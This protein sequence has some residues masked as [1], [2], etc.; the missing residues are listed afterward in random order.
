M[1]IFDLLSGLLIARLL[2]LAVLP[3]HYLLI[4]LWNPLV[5]L[6]IAHSAHI[7]AWMIFLT[8][9]AI[10]LTFK[11][12]SLSSRLGQFPTEKGAEIKQNGP[13]LPRRIGAASWARIAAPLV[14][15][16]AT[17]TKILPVLTIP[18]LFWR[19][20]WRQWLLYGLATI[21]FLL[22][23][24]W[25][26]GWG[27]T[28]PL[29]GTGL[30]GALRIY[31]SVWKFNSGLFYG[32]EQVLTKQ[33]LGDPLSTS[34]QIV[35]GSMVVVLFVVW[36]VARRQKGFRVSLRLTAVPFMAYILLT[37][38]VHPWYIL[39][40]I[41]FLPFLAPGEGESRWLWLLVLPWLY[42]SG[43]LIFSYLTYLDPLN[44]G[45]LEWVRRLQW[46]P[47]LILLLLTPIVFAAKYRTVK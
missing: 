2:T 22:P 4:Y 7:D 46:I 14:L 44:F 32:L 10:W 27:V 12:E 28:G 19:W 39:V 23:S 37:P 42:L 5:I 33:G 18:V 3:A 30:F 34:K 17:L 16:L 6:E 20:S 1:I 36:L 38:T 47:T 11:S 8:L 25:R 15:T 21:G 26:A 29:D 24:A 45:E 9:L 43:A 41:A 35:F 40:L 13:N 31:G